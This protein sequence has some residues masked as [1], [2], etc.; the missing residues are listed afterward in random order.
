[1]LALEVYRIFMREEIR[2]QAKARTV[3]YRNICHT[4]LEKLRYP[5]PRD[6]S[7]KIG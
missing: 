2:E 4:G 6:I 7:G 3:A 1:M 5:I